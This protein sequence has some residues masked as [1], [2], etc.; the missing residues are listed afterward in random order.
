MRSRGYERDGVGEGG[1]EGG[2]VGVHRD[3]W[4]GE[5]CRRIEGKLDM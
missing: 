2:G 3:G 5:D 4:C 1:K